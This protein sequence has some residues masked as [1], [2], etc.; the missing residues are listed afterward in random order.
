M[1]AP[2]VAVNSTTYQSVQL[3]LTSL[4]ADGTVE[5]QIG[6]RPDFKFC[7]APIITGLARTSP[8]T[9]NGLNQDTPYYIR[10]RSRRA[11]G[12][13]ESWSTIATAHTQLNNAP[14]LSTPAVLISPAMLVVPAPILEWTGNNTVAGFPCDNL[15]FD[16]PVAWRSS[17][18][19]PN[20]TA[21]FLARMAA[22]PVDTIALLMS[23]APESATVQVQAGNDS[24]TTSFTSTV[25]PFRASANLANR[26]GYHALIRLPTAQ[27]YPFWRV[28]VTIGG[29][30]LNGPFHLEHAVFGFNRVSKNH[31]VD[32]VEAPLDYGSFE[33]SAMGIPQRTLG[34][35]GKRVDFEISM[36][37]QL[38]FETLYADLPRLVGTT[39]P[40]LAVPNSKA[41][42]F[43]HDRILYGVL[44]GG[45]AVNPASPVYSRTFTIDSILP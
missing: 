9:F 23:N 34:L 12:A 25:F 33:R 20:T 15:G 17:S 28:T 44:S 37:N 22:Q 3:A 1:P 43:L 7:V 29:S 10:A 38:Q 6:T 42:A 30:G 4:A 5:V 40:V 41:G 14:D 24:S 35:R 18:A 2:T 21:S 16:A 31:S 27:S 45:K 13:A 39:S 8:Q 32:K 26:P 36:M 19:T 11:S